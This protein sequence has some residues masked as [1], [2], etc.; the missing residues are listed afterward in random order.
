MI[1]VQ[2]KDFMVKDVISASPS[3]SIKDVM[4]LFVGKKIG[5]LPII[6]ENG[7]LRGFVTDGDVLRAI[8]PVDR[9]IHDY[10]SLIT[11]VAEEDMENRLRE[12]ADREVIR[13]AKTHG[14]VTVH[15][16]D[17]M[18]KVV[19]LL[20]K[21]HFKKLPVVDESNH[22]VGVISRGDVIRSI[23]ETIINDWQ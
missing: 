2:V 19:S 18:K 6:D 23:Q 10:F 15:P 5:G 7:V 17:E 9:R 4:T 13:I 16:E 21:H 8:S 12:L 3:A 14:I 20:S 11:Y 22:V 1:N